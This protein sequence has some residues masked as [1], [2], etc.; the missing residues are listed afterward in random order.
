MKTPFPA[1]DERPPGYPADLERMLTLPDGRTVFIR[2]LLPADAAQMA[3]EISTLDE[4]TL[5]RRFMTPRPQLDADRIRYLASV[6][7]RWR[8]ALG[9]VDEDGRGV[10]VARYEGA[11]G[12]DSA[13]V[14]VA[15]R[16]EWR[17]QGLA[18][19]LFD[20][21]ADAARAHGLRRLT[22]VYLAE[23]RPAARLMAKAG[24]GPPRI[25]HGVGEV[26]KAL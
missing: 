24:Y 2:P 9:V 20:M 22:A 17:R 13:E 7:Y 18:L 15:V 6:D 21:L 19:A 23:N 11:P 16:P 5:Y 8:M 3:Q 12:S 4:D 1:V 26:E 25:H 10:A 14:A